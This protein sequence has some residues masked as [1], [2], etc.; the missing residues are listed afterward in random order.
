MKDINIISMIA[1]DVIIY[2][3]A[4]NDSK[5]QLLDNRMN[6]ALKLSRTWVQNNNM[7][8]NTITTVY[9]VFLLYRNHEQ[10]KSENTI[11]IT[12]DYKLRGK[13]HVKEVKGKLITC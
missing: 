9:Q 6:S 12:F 8:R 4:V 7:K 13:D 3:T 11:R 2:V 1:D 10:P 5:Q